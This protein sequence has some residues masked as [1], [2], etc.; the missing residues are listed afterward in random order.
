MNRA[1]SALREI[2]ENESLQI[3]PDE[4][5]RGIEGWDSMRAVTFQ[6]ELERIYEVDLSDELITGSSTLAGIE[7]VLRTKGA[8]PEALTS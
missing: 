2:C 7:R 1:K 4:P 8:H 3:S 5:L 6:L